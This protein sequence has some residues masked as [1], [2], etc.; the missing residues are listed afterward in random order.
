M[1]ITIE[2][3]SEIEASALKQAA[4]EGLPLNDYVASLV[5]DSIKRRE[6]NECSAAVKIKSE[7]PNVK[8]NNASLGVFIE[9]N[10]TIKR[11]DKSI[12]EICNNELVEFEEYFLWQ[13]VRILKFFGI[14]SIAKLD[15]TLKKQENAILEFAR[16][17]LEAKNIQGAFEKGISIFYLGLLLASSSSDRQLVWQ[18]LESNFVAH[19][20]NEDLGAKAIEIYESMPEQGIFKD[21]PTWDEFM[22]N[23]RENRRKADELVKEVD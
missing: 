15:E 12:A 21:D 14:N 11:L 4:K 2:L 6:K 23:I 9:N 20:N 5:K 13:K 19:D 7:L 18:F 17:W 16:E 8:I 3:T 10:E 22:E 1:S